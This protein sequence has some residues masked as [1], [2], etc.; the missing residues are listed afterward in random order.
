ML[1]RAGWDA[2]P[3]PPTKAGGGPAEGIQAPR[4]TAVGAAAEGRLV[5][6][7]RGR[8]GPLGEEG[9]RPMREKGRGCIE[10]LGAKAEGCA[11]PGRESPP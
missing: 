10:P 8:R 3:A 2:L 1:A 5:K 4:A 6:K 7:A 9:A 11:P